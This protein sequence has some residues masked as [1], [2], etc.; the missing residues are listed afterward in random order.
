MTLKYLFWS[1]SKMR[2]PFVALRFIFGKYI[3]FV[4]HLHECGIWFVCYQKWFDLAFSF[5]FRLIIAP[6]W[7][8]MSSS[9]SAVQIYDLSYIIC[10]ICHWSMNW[11]SHIIHHILLPEQL[12]RRVFVSREPSY[13]S[14]KQRSLFSFV[15]ALPSALKIRK[16][17]RIMSNHYCTVTNGETYICPTWRLYHIWRFF[18]NFCQRWTSLICNCQPTWVSKLNFHCLQV[19]KRVYYGQEHISTE[20]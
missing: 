19:Y 8:I 17:P 20:S 14:F 18:L 6:Q 10:I 7:S 16:H 4:C 1:Q 5:Q 15:S 3:L 9:F 13:N 12:S 2:V 11:T